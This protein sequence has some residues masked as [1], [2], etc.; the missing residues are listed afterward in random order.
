[1]PIIG[2]CHSPSFLS[3]RRV[4]LAPKIY[5]GTAGLPHLSRV[6]E[7][8]LSI[9]ITAVIIDKQGKSSQIIFIHP[10]RHIFYFYNSF[11]LRIYPIIV[12][13][14]FPNFIR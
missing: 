10:L 4:Y 8:K 14:F 9:R 5:P 2:A 1:M 13:F 6:Q 3:R 11:S 12:C 7:F